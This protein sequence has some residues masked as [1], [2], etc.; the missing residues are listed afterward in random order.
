MN[1]ITIPFHK[2]LHAFFFFHARKK[3]QSSLTMGSTNPL[4]L[5]QQ[6]IFLKGDPLIA[7]GSFSKTPKSKVKPTRNNKSSLLFNPTNL[8]L[9][10][11]NLSRTALRTKMLPNEG[12]DNT[13]HNPEMKP[14]NLI[15]R[16]SLSPPNDP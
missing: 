16:D 6:R 14:I 12:T 15:L 5:T 13:A 3:N 9:S 10:F 7:P 11:Q 8:L 4:L 1:K 2:Y